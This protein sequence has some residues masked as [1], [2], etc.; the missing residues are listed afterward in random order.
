MT[1]TRRS[2]LKFGGAMLGTLATAAL[3][4]LQ[5][6]AARPDDAFKS[7]SM[8]D[9]EKLLG[10]TP[11]DSADIDFKTPDIAENGAV[12]PVSIESNIPGTSEIMIL[13][14]QNPNPLSA[15]FLIP[16]GTKPAVS[17]RIKVAQTSNLIAVVKANGKLY[18]STKE[19]KV[20]LGGCGG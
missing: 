11:T 4:P 2:F 16:E 3:W 13:V 9:L 7:K 20:T 10:G 15:M 14:E 17:T 12:V 6:F 8:T 1:T 5:V 18:S 19:T